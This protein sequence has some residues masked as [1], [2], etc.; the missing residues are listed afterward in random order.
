M[1]LALSGAAVFASAAS[2]GAAGPPARQAAVP[3][4][5]S[6]P[7]TAAAGDE[8][9]LRGSCGDDPATSAQVFSSLAGPVTLNPAGGFLVATFRVPLDAEEGDYQ[10]ALRCTDGQRANSVLH[11][12]EG[13]TEP[14]TPTCPQSCPPPTTPPACPQTC[15]PTT[16]PPTTTPP[17]CPQT[18]PPTTTPPTTTPPTTTPPTTT[19]PT[20]TPP[21]ICVPTTTPP[22]DSPDEP[23]PGSSEPDSDPDPGSLRMPFPGSG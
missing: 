15:P 20:T 9:G 13:G 4:I 1:P 18:C 5:E 12:R 23:L 3:F 8:V 14:E 16:T 17:A 6:S 22:T 7:A 11:V 19:P 2:G 10:L 21:T